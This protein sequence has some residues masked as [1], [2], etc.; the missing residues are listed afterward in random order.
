MKDLNETIQL[1]ELWFDQ[2]GLTTKG[3][4]IKQAEKGV[5]EAKEYLVACMVKDREAMVDELGD[6]FVT[7]IGDSIIADIP[8]DEALYFAYQK[9]SNRVGKGC[10]V[11][12]TFVKEEDLN[13]N[14][15]Q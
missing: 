1:V 14:N 7:L 2:V 5:E 13:N 15:V 9:I 12:G 4:P 10:I 8:L 11:D 3:D 6:K